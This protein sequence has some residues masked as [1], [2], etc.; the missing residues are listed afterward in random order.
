MTD[1]EKAEKLREKAN[2]SF[3]EAKEALVNS[4]G[5]MLD[6]MIYLEKQ[7]KSTQPNGGGYYSS[8]GVT[9]HEYRGANYNEGSRPQ[10]DGG[11]SFSDMMRR[12]GRFCARML[13][14]GVT[15]YLDA[16]KGD[17]LMFSCPVL[18]AVV[19]LIFF[20]W[21]T[22]PLFI[23]SLFLGFRYQFRGPDLGRESFNNAMDSASQA[24]EEVKR[25]FAERANESNNTGE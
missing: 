4:D 25:S 22:V 6:A 13:N 1:F 21:I 3:E 11:E 14:K 24:V 18:A 9:E 23:I 15:N 8:D 19:L 10:G 16:T 7:G 2:V 12:F 17:R 5:D 20:F